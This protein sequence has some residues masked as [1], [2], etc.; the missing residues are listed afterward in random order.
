MPVFNWNE[1]G[2]PIV[3][4]GFRYYWAVTVP[5]TCLV[6]VSWGL[7]MLLPWRDWLSNVK[8][9]TKGNDTELAVIGL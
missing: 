2:V 3:T 6:L 5:L 7:A 1:E 8:K 4:K 9:S